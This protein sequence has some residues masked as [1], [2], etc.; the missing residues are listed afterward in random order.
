MERIRVLRADQALRRGDAVNVVAVAFIPPKK[1]V[2]TKRRRHE[3]R[4][5]ERH[6]AAVARWLALALR[7]ER[8]I[9]EQVYPTKTVLA[10]AHGI[11]SARL[12]QIL[13]LG[14]L[15]PDIQEEVLALRFPAGR[16]PINEREL[17]RVAMLLSWPEQREAWVG[18]RGRDGK[19]RGL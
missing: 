19:P 15:A 5:Q 9:D 13:L 11:T 4:L 10:A 3:A 7:I 1:V 18:I 2:S 12:S 14:F 16:Q 6:P 17:L 8:E